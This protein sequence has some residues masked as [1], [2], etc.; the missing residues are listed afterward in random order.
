MAARENLEVL[1]NSAELDEAEESPPNGAA[2]PKLVPIPILSHALSNTSG[3]LILN[4]D[5]TI[6][7]LPL[8]EVYL[9]F[10]PAG[11]FRAWRVQF[12]AL[13]W[14][15]G[16]FLGVQLRCTTPW[17]RNLFKPRPSFAL[18]LAYSRA[19]HY[20][21]LLPPDVVLSAGGQ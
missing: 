20:L 4:T 3:L 7:Y 11:V 13:N 18:V 15:P 19:L 12:S 14:R 17:T 21:K 8:G 9:G 5:E 6:R 1:S 16:G 2:R 10:Q